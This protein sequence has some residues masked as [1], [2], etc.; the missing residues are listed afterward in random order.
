IPQG[1]HLGTT[2]KT[3]EYLRDE[4]YY[5]PDI[6]EPNAYV[7]IDGAFAELSDEANLKDLKP[8]MMGVGQL[9]TVKKNILY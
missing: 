9:G 7:R 2:T 8:Q 5:G 3:I 1:L 6:N 4:E